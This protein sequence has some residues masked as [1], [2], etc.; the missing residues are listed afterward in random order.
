MVAI[1][2]LET[3]I[4]KFGTTLQIA[5]DNGKQFISDIFEQLCQDLNISHVRTIPYRPQFN[6][7]NRTNRTLIQTIEAYVGN[8]HENWDRNL[9]KFAYVL[10]TVT[11]AS[12]EKFPAK[13][14]LERKLT[15]F[16][17]LSFTEN[18]LRERERADFDK[19][20]AKA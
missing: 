11:H 9:T 13:L 18:Q 3:F 5:S 6:L 4:V 16:K 17:K 12:T 7:P 1:A 2:I 20:I 19:L 10:R 15:P 14:F 8:F